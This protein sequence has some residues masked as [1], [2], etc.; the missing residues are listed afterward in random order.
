MAIEVD[1]FNREVEGR[2]VEETLLVT[3]ALEEYRSLVQENAE[4]E[5]TVNHLS[6]ELRSARSEKVGWWLD[7]CN[8]TFTCS[9]CD[10]RSS[11]MAYCGHCGARM[12]GVK[13]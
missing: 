2:I 10:G 9:L 1:Y 8:G 12:G 3:I 4:L 13:V 5:A 11:K 6:E 7:N